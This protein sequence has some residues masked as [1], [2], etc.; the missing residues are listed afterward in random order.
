MITLQLVQGYV[1]QALPGVIPRGSTR[2]K[3]KRAT[4]IEVPMRGTLVHI[5][6][7][8]TYEYTLQ[9]S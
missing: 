6:H 3:K 8:S 2:A 7:G 9:T 4:T 1:G 5:L